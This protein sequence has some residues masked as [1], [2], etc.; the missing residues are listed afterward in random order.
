MIR[1]LLL[2]LSLALAHPATAEMARVAS[3]EHADYTRLVIELP[4][5]TDWTVGRTAMGYGFATVQEVQPDY[6]LDRVW[7]RIPRTRLQSL[8]IDPVSGA[9]QLALACDCHVVPFSFRPNMV[10]LDIRNG[11]APSDSRFEDPL[12]LAADPDLQPPSPAPV[13]AQP[14]RSTAAGYD[15]RAGLRGDL[16]DRAGAAGDLPSL[17]TGGLSLEPLRDQLLEQISRGAADGVVQM[18]MPG[19]PPAL[20]G[21]SW[22]E[23]PWTQIRIGEAAGVEVRSGGQD[24]PVVSASPC[25]SAES[26]DLEGWGEGLLPLDLIAQTRGGLYGEFDALSETALERAIRAHLHLGFGA[27]ARTYVDM[28]EPGMD[29]ALLPHYRSLSFLVDGELDPQT[30][31]AQMLDCDGPAALWAALARDRL[32]PGPEV[33]SEAIVAAFLALPAHLR[34]HLGPMLAERLLAR[35]DVE[36]ARQVRNAVARTPQTAAATVALLDAKAELHLGE[37]E[38]AQ[39]LAEAALSTEADRSDGLVT[40][41]EAHFRQALPLSPD[42]PLTLRTLAREADGS[43]EAPA[44]RRALVL[45][46][47]LSGDVAGAFVEAEAGEGVTDDLWQ[48]VATLATDDA[49][50][51]HTVLGQ[52]SGRPEAAVETADAI[53]ARLVGLGFGEPALRWLGPVTP[54]DPEPRRRT[55]AAAEL[56]R[57]GSQAALDLLAGLADPDSARLRAEALIQQGD[58]ASARGALQSAGAT[59]QAAG[60]LPWEGNWRALPE[61]GAEPWATA[62]AFAEGDQAVNDGGPLARGEELLADSAAMRA[63]MAGL[64]EAV[65]TPLE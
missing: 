59:D 3:G 2:A 9:L 21:N 53:A 12:V 33:N 7:Q 20:Q 64:L 63:A 30:S 47:A 65:P 18:Q 61:L 51:A 35:D 6:D 14:M 38:A 15:W 32:P 40:L 52:G 17:A 57:G 37:P 19:A 39:G 34:H 58:Y 26:L 55:A 48:V 24:L 50:L 49:F 13:P 43:S 27:E 10:V 60:L 28:A 45:A 41:V 25:V 46:L 16:G 44:L 4:A 31:F 11:P 23:L 54:I 8:R 29:M 36:A 1:L 62:A 5:A 42:I 56:L 22:G